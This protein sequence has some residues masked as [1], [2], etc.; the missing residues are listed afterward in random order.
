[1]DIELFSGEPFLAD[2]VS[3]QMEELTIESTTAMRKTVKLYAK[4]L[5]NKE[6]KAKLRKIGRSYQVP[7]QLHTD[8]M[9]VLCGLNGGTAQDVIIA[10]LSAGLEK[11]SNTAI[12]NITRFGNVE[13][14]WQLIQKYTG[15]VNTDDRPL[16]ELAA[17][18]L[19]TAL[20]QTMNLSALR[21]LD[22]F[23]FNSCTAFCYQLIREWQFSGDNSNLCEIC[24]YV[25]RELRL[26]DRFDKMEISDL[27]N[28]D[29]FPAI[30]ESILKRL[31]TEICEQVIKVDII[32]P[33]VENR[34]TA[35][36]YNLFANYFD[37]LFNIG[38]AQEFYLAHIKGFH[39]VEPKNI[40][41]LYTSE[42]YL[43]DSHYRRFHYAFGNTLKESNPSLDDL[44]KK[45]AEVVE[46]LYCHWYL[47]EITGAWTSAISDDLNTLGYISEI[48]RQRDFFVNTLPQLSTR[49]IVSLSLFPM[50]YG[51]KLL[52]NWLIH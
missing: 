47:K 45:C 52:L 14:F 41:K 44:L 28:S 42:G 10:V 31:L 25:E 8:I 13:A 12:S 4:F 48:T 39:I 15:Y 36:W 33:T 35:A 26:A 43:M 29:T 30:N 51:M 20:S 3:M 46:R 50:P 6:R 16:E 5:E 21:G 49:A 7:L 27:I 11:E 17:H 22:R 34:R 40:W 37:C 24:R 2:L 1:M 38:K 9:A 32:L 23:I 18:I 19:I